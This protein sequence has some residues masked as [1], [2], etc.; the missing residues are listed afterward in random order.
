M[1]D[2]P[3]FTPPE[4]ALDHTADTAEQFKEQL[5]KFSQNNAGGYNGTEKAM[6]PE[7][8]RLTTN[9]EFQRRQINLHDPGKGR[10][11]DFCPG[12]VVREDDV[13]KMVVSD[14]HQLRGKDQW[15][16]QTMAVINE[17]LKS[18]RRSTALFK[19]DCVIEPGI[20]TLSMDPGA[21]KELLVI[22]QNQTI[23]YR[24]NCSGHEYDPATKDRSFRKKFISN[25]LKQERGGVTAKIQGEKYVA[26]LLGYSPER[27]H[28]FLRLCRAVKD[29]DLKLQDSDSAVA[30][31]RL[32]ENGVTNLD[33]FQEAMARPKSYPQDKVR[34]QSLNEEEEKIYQKYLKYQER[35]KQRVE[36]LKLHIEALRRAKD[37]NFEILDRL[38]NL[39]EIIFNF[40]N[41]NDNSSPRDIAK[42]RMLDIRG[43]YGTI[44]AL[45][46]LMLQ[47]V[48][49]FVYLPV[50]EETDIDNL[51][52]KFE[53]T[54]DVLEQIIHGEELPP[55]LD[56]N[57]VYH[58][59]DEMFDDKGGNLTDWT[60]VDSLEEAVRFLHSALSVRSNWIS[61][62]HHAIDPINQGERIFG[63]EKA[64]GIIAINIS[65]RELKTLP[66]VAVMDRVAE[67]YFDRH[68]KKGLVAAVKYDLTPL[69]IAG[70]DFAEVTIQGHHKIELTT[71]V[72]DSDPQDYTVRW[73]SFEKGYSGA[74]T[75]LVLIET[76]LKKLGFKDLKTKGASDKSV[77]MCLTTGIRNDWEKAWSESYRLAVGINNVDMLDNP[78]L[79]PQLADMFTDGI[80]D[81]NFAIGSRLLTN[82]TSESMAKSADDFYHIFRVLG[83]GEQLVALRR[84]FESIEN[85]NQLKEWLIKFDANSLDRVISRTIDLE[86][87]AKQAKDR[88]LKGRYHRIVERLISYYDERFS[89]RKTVD[90]SPNTQ[91]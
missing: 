36:E 74:N 9:F 16:D 25:V 59:F 62:D 70:D 44:V 48:R 76:I 7:L 81:L 71:Q 84:V 89:G 69:L 60:A 77:D 78:A 85:F 11:F 12:E 88:K 27:L 67:N 49:R 43:T 86:D 8:R 14:E 28:T 55:G 23:Y 57:A 51:A 54:V 90:L 35:R 50:P 5:A 83:R 52:K 20:I 72:K 82:R 41:F 75:R 17:E 45:L 4:I 19:A 2:I 37:L 1:S 58:E 42:A 65:G 38:S 80:T 79:A 30:A 24:H 31:A 10:T 3:Q 68:I 91:R 40:R 26:A 87:E 56:V 6:P 18:F 53:P 15:V 22:V 29:M 64:G 63:E 61:T 66:A 21:H 34:E 39:Q 33:N 13:V 47:N 46:K 73:R 32:F